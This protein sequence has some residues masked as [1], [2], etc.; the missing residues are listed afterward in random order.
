[1]NPVS[2]TWEENTE[3]RVGILEQKMDKV[4]D[5]RDGIYPT[6]TRIETRMMRWAVAILSGI[7][8]NLVLNLLDRVSS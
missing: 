3:R 7:V 4:L 5:P 6:V 8:A 1:M 2:T